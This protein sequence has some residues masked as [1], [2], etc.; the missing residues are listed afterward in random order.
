MMNPTKIKEY[1]FYYSMNNLYDIKKKENS[2]F[3]DIDIYT[4]ILEKLFVLYLKIIESIRSRMYS[5]SNGL[6]VNLNSTI[7]STTHRTSFR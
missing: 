2:L 4:L 3:L 1:L 5:E 6:K 7:N